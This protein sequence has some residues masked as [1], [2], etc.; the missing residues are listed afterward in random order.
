MG[1]AGLNRV[2]PAFIAVLACQGC[3]TAPS[4]QAAA[5]KEADAR[6]VAKCTLISTVVGRSLIG[7]VGSTGATNAITDAKEQASGL[8]ATHVVLLSVD[9]GSIYAT[10]TATA[11]AY[12]CN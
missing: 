11:R 9:S 6:Q 5:I 10:A 1:V 4:Y 12:R 2:L 8:G 3:A 7:G